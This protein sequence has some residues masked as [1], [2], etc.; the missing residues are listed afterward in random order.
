MFFGPFEISDSEYV[1]KARSLERAKEIKASNI[2]SID[3]EAKN[4]CIEGSDG[5]VY[6]VS[7]EQC[8]CPDYQRHQ[9]VCKHMIRLALDLGNAFDV[10][11]FDP[12]K[13]AGYN[14]QDDIALLTKRWENGELTLDALSKCIAA[15]NSSA[16]K[17]KHRK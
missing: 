16:K 3:L 15:L 4:A 14:V 9:S 13:A 5:T 11:Q 2:K 17:A 1:D 8:S 6:S 7:L 10:P 12:Y